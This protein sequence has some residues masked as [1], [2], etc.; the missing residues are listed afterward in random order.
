MPTFRALLIAALCCSRAPAADPPQPAP[1]F[2]PQHAARME[3]GL[4]LFQTHV[5]PLLVQNC[6]RCHG[7]EDTEAGFNLAMREGLLKGG[8]TGKAVIPGDSAGSRLMKLVRHAEEPHMPQDAAKLSD[9]AIAHLADWIDNLAPYDAPLVGD[10][11]DTDWTIRK[12]DAEA[13]DFWSLLPLTRPAI[14]VVA[15]QT[16]CRT[17]IDR[18]IAVALE[19]HQLRPND[20][21]QRRVLIRRAY[22]DL[23]GLPPDPAAVDAFVHDPAPDAWERLV[24]RL[25]ADPHYGERWGR[26]WL[27]L[28]RFA[29]SHGFEHDY[30]RASAYH[31]RDFVI[32]ALNAGLPYDQFVQ[33]QLAGDE[34]APDDRL[35][36]MAT[37]F[38]AAGVHS[39]QIT[40]S[41]AE[42]H[43]Y[44]EMDDMLNTACTAFL[45]LTIGCARCHD[46]KFDPIPMA[47]YY[48]M[49][50][51]FTSTIRSE[52]DV[53][54]DPAANAAAQSRHEREHAPFVAAL[55]TWEQR[56][57]RQKFD[58]WATSTQALAELPKWIVLNLTHK[59]RG[60]ATLQPQPDGSL[61]ATGENPQHEQYT[62]T[63]DIDLPPVTAVR[64]EAL[65]DASLVKGGPGR[66]SNGNFALSDF[67][68]SSRP[69]GTEQ[70]STEVKL[71]DAI[72]TFQQTAPDLPVKAAIDSDPNTA[73]AVDP[74]FGKNHA[75]VFGLG[76]PLALDGP[77]ELTFT[78]SFNNNTQH[79]IGRPRLSVTTAERPLS[80]EGDALPQGVVAALHAAPTDR[81]PEQTAALFDWYRQ[82]DPQWQRLN[83]AVTEHAAKA[84]QPVLTKVLIASEG[85]PP[86]KLH[87]QSPREF[88]DETFFLKRGDVNQKLRPAEPGYLQAVSFVDN[89]EPGEP[90]RTGSGPLSIWAA[91]ADWHPSGRRTALARWMTDPSD[92][93]GRLLARVIVNRLWQHHFGRGIVATPSDFGHQGER[94]THPELLD[95]LASELIAHDWD[96]KPIHKLIMTSAVYCQSSALDDA[97]A[98]TNPDNRWLWRYPRQRLEGEVIR[99]ALLAV[100]GRLD[101]RLYGPG[102]LDP[103]MTRRSIYFTVKR[104][105]LV[106]AML[107]FD[108][109]DAL[110]GMAARPTTTVAP[111]ALY[112]MNNDQVRQCAAALAARLPTGSDAAGIVD[113]AYESVLGR[114][115]E[116]HEQT[117]IAAFLQRQMEIHRSAG[118]A[119]VS[120]QAA[121]DLCHVLL[122]L[123]EFAYVE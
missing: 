4:K 67:R 64:L 117:A 76:Q 113:E 92:G 45:G 74:E 72:A 97:R 41:E 11:A 16:W 49:L 17:P 116:A 6:L 109:P 26:H 71:V 105:Q 118:H 98:S 44:D 1:P 78:L 115:P 33:W 68:V 48:R 38:L 51:T 29:E 85:L 75:A 57:L 28:A 55:Q 39:T 42:R 101:D 103:A 56:E 43:R 111:Q 25:L 30:D 40:I 91:P 81:T 59:S 93:A 123:N 27:D 2:D 10:D 82:R 69:A 36:L 95:W 8:E 119:D 86:L 110:G 50:S 112:L 73:W 5:R 61:L 80:L 107:V 34:L 3:A 14:P 108:A 96:L 84:P 9:A 54:F 37:G 77:L 100:S 106:P 21:A 13:R 22:L 70:P 87:T 23:L 62:F 24:D 60:G 47:D 104:S 79:S 122:S 88:F 58:A 15:N 20:T 120:R 121:T 46:H 94:P 89:V 31:Y 114:E 12:V 35:A 19:R 63:A 99:D 18:F 102:S 32:E 7:G 53:D 90:R 66:A 65:S 83:A 52:I